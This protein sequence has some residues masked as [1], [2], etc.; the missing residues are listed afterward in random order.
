MIWAIVPAA[1]RGTRFGGDVPKQYLDVA[2]RPLIAHALQRAAGASARRRRDGRAGAG[3]RAL[4]GLDASSTASRCCTCV[5]GGERADSVLA[6]LARA[7]RRRATPTTAVLVHDAARPV[8]ARATT[9]TACSTVGRGD[10]VGAILAAPVRD[11]LKRA[12]DD[13]GIDGTEPRE[14]LW[15]ALTPQ[16]FRRAAADARAGSGARRAASRSPTRRWRWSG[17]GHRPLLVE[18]S[19]DNLKVTTPADLALAEFLLR[20]AATSARRTRTHEHAASASGFDVHAFGEG[21]H[22]DARRRARAARRA[23]C[24]AHSDGDVV[25]HAL[26]DAMLGA[27]ALGDIGTAFPADRSAAGRTPTA[28]RSCAT[29]LALVARARL[30]RRQRRHHRDLRASRRSGRMREAMRALLAAD[31]G[32]DVDAVSVKATTTENARLHRPR[33]RHRRAGGVP[34]GARL[35][36]DREPTRLAARARRRGAARADARARRRIS[37]VEELA[38][39]EP[40]GSGEHLLLTIEKRGMNTAFAAQAHRAVGRHRRDRRRLRRAEG[41]P[42][43]HPPALQR[44]PAEARRAGPRARST[45]RTTLRVLDARLA[46]AQAA[47][48]RAGRQPLRAGAARRAGRARRDRGAPAGDRRARRAQLFRRAA[49]RPRRRQRRRRRWRCSPDAACVANSARSCCRRRARS[50]STACWRARVADGTLGPA[51][52]RARCGC[53]TA[54]AACSAR[55]RWTTSWPRGWRAFDIH[56]TGPLWGTGERCAAPARAQRSKS[57]ARRQRCR[58]AARRPGGRRP[59]AGAPRAAPAAAKA[60][61][62]AGSTMARWRWASRCRPAPTPRWCWPNWATSPASVA[63]ADRRQ[64]RRRD[65]TLVTGRLQASAYK[66]ELRTGIFV[67]CLGVVRCIRTGGVVMEMSS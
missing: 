13:G 65:M 34:A 38:G 54:A 12:G 67:A 27:L 9:S 61:T 16:L 7:A 19:E 56:P 26:C 62:G 24:V 66:P 17:M 45:V 49:L 41:P 58:R 42:R 33:R 1:G 47:A 35:T 55:S 32:V 36:H 46:C 60:C 37:V 4:A 21:D 64:R 15:R 59:E 5:G 22:V 52:S 18:G 50:C 40:S 57:R 11:T 10:P 63:T 29:A 2:G 28:A 48:R 43:G 44:A 3:R 8:P 14:R 6:A 53:S 20:L 30:A 31:L 39:F 25:I 51:R 23:A